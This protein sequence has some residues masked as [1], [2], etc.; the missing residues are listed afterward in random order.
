MGSKS[1]ELKKLFLRFYHSNT[2]TAFDVN[3]ATAISNSFRRGWNWDTITRK[4]GSVELNNSLVENVL[5]QLKSPTDAKAALGF[6]HWATKRNTYQH[7]TRSY[8]IAIHVLLGAT[9]VT[10][11]KALLE[12][13]SNKY[14]DPIAVRAVVDSL[15]DTCHLVASG[16]RHLAVNLL[17][18]T[19]ARM[20]VMEVAFYVCR[21]AMERGFSVSVVSFN[22][23]LHVVQRSEKC[24]FVWDVYECMIQRRI[25]P[26]VV[27]FRI[28]IDALCKEG[29]LENVVNTV[30]RIMGKRSSIAPS[31]IVN[32][33]LILRM[34]ERG[35]VEEESVVVILLKR[36]LQKNLISD[37]VAYSLIV[38]TKVVFGNLDS[39]WELYGEMLRR[40]LQANSF[41]YTS[42]IGAFCRD[43]R[44]GEAIGLM[45]EMEG[46]GLKPYGQTF[47]H[48]IVG[49][50][51][52]DRLEECLSV[53][54][55][56]LIVGIVPGCLA[57]NK[58][59]EKLCEKGNMEK[60]NAM[61]TML[62]DKGFVPDDVMFFNMMRGYSEKN[63][64]Q[65]VLKL[66]YEMEYRSMSPGLSVF[67]LII[68]SLCRC[69]KV[70]DA[71]KYLRIMRGR[72]ITPDVT[73]YKALI[74]G[75]MKKGDSVRALHLHNEMVSL[76]LQPSY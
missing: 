21:Y 15:L 55:K 69:G 57:F 65:E 12:S 50:V 53:F 46:K 8:C 27:S 48:V 26:T 34:L 44:I 19:Y 40:G 36:L 22:S 75:Q 20:R 72:S 68:Q 63:E 30:D 4:F 25:Y 43:G 7:Q 16:S 29:E 56:M 17:I 18:Q 10:D 42:F 66:Y 13:L 62:M 11:A 5:L 32:C 59:V 23:L 33:G 9:L 54:E 1:K 3:M 2:D 52:S 6:F 39:V 14:T 51:D 74:A 71:E 31:V 49:C 41:V 67:A 58:V 45:H 61:L 76:E 35:Q 60:A 28:M 64:V 70:E 73:V 37:S 47:E 38:H 24:G